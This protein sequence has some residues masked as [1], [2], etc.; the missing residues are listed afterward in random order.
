MAEN[1]NYVELACIKQGSKLRVKI[2]SAGYLNYANC[3]F[4]RDIRIEGAK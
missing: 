1:I 4:P 2:V 3:Q